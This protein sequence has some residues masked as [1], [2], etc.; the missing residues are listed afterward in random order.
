MNQRLVGS[1]ARCR[2]TVEAA[3]EEVCGMLMEVIREGGGARHLRKPNTTTRGKQANFN[4]QHPLRVRDTALVLTRTSSA[5]GGRNGC[6]PNT[7]SNNSAPKFHMS[8]ASPNGNP[9]PA[10]AP[11]PLAEPCSNG[12]KAASGGV[13]CSVWKGAPPPHSGNGHRATRPSLFQT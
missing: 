7:A 5:S 13:D 6:M 11:A 4:P 12:S 8:S 1:K 3:L 9:P 10:L 2:I